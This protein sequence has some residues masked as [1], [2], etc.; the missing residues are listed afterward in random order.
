MAGRG[1]TVGAPETMLTGFLN[2]RRSAGQRGF[3]LTEVMV[4]MTVSTVVAGALMLSLTAL[5]RTFTATEAYS[6]AQAAQIRLI[7][8]VAM[9]LRRAIGVAI[10][11]APTSN[12]AL[13][14]NTTVR[15]AY[16]S[17]SPAA[18]TMTVRNGKYDYVNERIGTGTGPSTYLTLTLPGFYQNQSASSAN[19]RKV[20]TL[21]STGRAVRYGT[22]AG[23]GADVTVQYRR[24]YVP[25]YNAECY[26]RRESGVDQ[27]IAEKANYMDLDVM[28][29]ADSSFVVDAWF[30]P[31]FS[32]ARER[33]ITRV[34]S[35]DRVMLRNPRRD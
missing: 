34:T 30:T 35:S 16:N 21:I 25:T 19:F 12:P 13:A 27:V 8:S 33:G 14:S 23:V 7:D 31:T 4:A 32:N 17:A 28:A 18:N 15:F 2:F 9:D 29:Q 26:I 20:T 11:T 10:T 24:A 5:S 3:T 1:H 22:S 6:R